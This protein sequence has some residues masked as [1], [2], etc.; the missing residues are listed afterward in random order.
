MNGGLVIVKRMAFLCS[1][2]LLLLTACQADDAGANTI[3]KSTQDT[4]VDLT[5]TN[6]EL[7][8]SMINLTYDEI[9]NVFISPTSALLALL[10]LYNGADGET[11]AEIESA[12]K[13]DGYSVEDINAASNKQMH[14]LQT[15]DES[16]EVVIANSFWINDKYSFRD[17][18]A[19]KITEHYEATIEEI[20]IAD[21]ESAQRINE[22]VKQQTNDKITDIVE[23]PLPEDLLAYILNA[24]Y[25]N[26]TWKYEFDQSLTT[27]KIFY[28]PNGEIEIPFMTLT[29]ELPYF[30]TE[31]FQA[32][33]LPYGSELL[34]MLILLPNENGSMTNLIQ[35]LSNNWENW[36]G[37]FEQTEGTV[38]MPKFSL[39]FEV[40][41]NDILQQLGMKAAFDAHQA[42]FSKMA[43]ATERIY[44]SE[45]KQKTYI[46]VHEEGTEAAATTSVEVRLTSAPL[47]G[48]VPFYME[49]NR[50]FLFVI[51][52]EENKQILFIGT[53]QQPDNES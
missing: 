25:F 5:E 8:F 9:E 6:N 40:I 3:D 17:E 31:E 36:Q 49:I 41:L 1:F 43:E 47:E 22:W 18:F 53:M 23:A 33:K 45:V 32:V 30:E 48:E 12:L 27:E 38:I 51:Q 46:D 10:M 37:Q 15:K 4:T 14:D 44:I 20:N 2:C 13:L 19:N 29:E 50:P 39:E 28:A 35:S 7:G 21:S 26:G 42:D 34:S 24:L 11:K 16:I 52:D